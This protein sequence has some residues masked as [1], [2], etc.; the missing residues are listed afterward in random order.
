MLIPINQ[1]EYPTN[2]VLCTHTQQVS[3]KICYVYLQT[4]SNLYV[5]EPRNGFN[6]YMPSHA[7]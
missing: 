3:P 4:Q 2:V 6:Q 5:K 7:H 1:H